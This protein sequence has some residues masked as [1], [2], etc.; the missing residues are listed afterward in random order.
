MQSPVTGSHNLVPQIQAVEA[1]Y[2][3]VDKRQTPGQRE[4]QFQAVFNTDRMEQ[5]ERKEHSLTIHKFLLRNNVRILFI[6][7]SW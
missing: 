3:M 1:I 4:I 5:E 2:S 6:Y 7:C